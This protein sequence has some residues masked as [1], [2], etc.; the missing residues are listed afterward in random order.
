M[1]PISIIDFDKALTQV[2]ASV[3]TRDL[4][5]YI[6]WNSQ[7]GSTEYRDPEDV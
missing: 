5:L 6:D 1:R 3:S 4:Q 2:R 7:F